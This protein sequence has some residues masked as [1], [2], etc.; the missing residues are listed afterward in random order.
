M[1]DSISRVGY[2]YFPDDIHFTET[3]AAR[4]IPILKDLGA[5]W[6]ILKSS[7]DR[8]VPQY[9]LEKIMA[10]GIEPV[11]HIP[12][13]VGPQLKNLDSM[14]ISY[15]NCGIR[16]VVVYDR[17]NMR[18]SWHDREWTRGRLVE[19]FMDFMLPILERELE[20]GLIPVL[21]PLE[22][23]GDYWDT[24]FLES[25][26]QILQRRAPRQIIDH[27][28]L[29][30]YGWTHSHPLDWGKGGPHA[31]PESLPYHTPENSQDQ[32][33]INIYEWYSEIARN[34]SGNP[35]PMLTLAGGP[36]AETSTNAKQSHFAEQNIA[37][38]R[39]LQDAD[40]HP[41]MLNFAFYCL[42]S[43]GKDVVPDAWFKQ[44]DTP[45][46]VVELFRTYLKNNGH[47]SSITNSTSNPAH[48]DP[49]SSPPAHSVPAAESTSPIPPE[50]TL[51]HYVLLPSSAELDRLWDWEAFG[52]FVRTA[53]PSIGFS[54][55]EAI[56]AQRV[57]LVGDEMVF[58]PDLEQSLNQAGCLVSRL[59]LSM[60]ETDLDSESIEPSAGIPAVTTGAAHG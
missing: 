13:I 22:P 53:K 37:I 42:A 18:R 44:E 12:A 10:A 59:D 17:P 9:F 24:V 28:V 55:D 11:I 35:L 43:N 1:K 29:G 4:W 14:L 16:Y 26:L 48:N 30:I 27:L 5:R 8:A 39:S 49:D 33:G 2:H 58:P 25:A 34:C 19:R 20:L 50:K 7:V 47:L 40:T 60:I 23:G 52:E 32:R 31:W 3:D 6:L 57:T 56:L 45:L 21:P 38:L 46:P 41:H 36:R 54:A 51:R 15:A